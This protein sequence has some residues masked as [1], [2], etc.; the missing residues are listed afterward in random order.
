MSN[1]LSA[2]SSNEAIRGPDHGNRSR[3]N[4]LTPCRDPAPGDKR[5]AKAVETTI[6]CIRDR[7]F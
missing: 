3:D 5:A 6:F 2:E 1:G 4:E 7:P